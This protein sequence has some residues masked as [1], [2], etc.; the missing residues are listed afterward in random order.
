[1]N[2]LAI[3]FACLSTYSE[4]VFIKC[5]NSILKCTYHVAFQFICDNIKFLDMKLEQMLSTEEQYLKLFRLSP[6]LATSF[7]SVTLF[8]K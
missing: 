8:S 6:C 5:G 7:N 3:G 2:S 1:M 4:C